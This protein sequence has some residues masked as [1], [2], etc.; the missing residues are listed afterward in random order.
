M[1]GWD[2]CIF[3][4]FRSSTLI[5]HR[6]CIGGRVAL[7][8]SYTGVVKSTTVAV[9]GA[10]GGVTRTI[11]QHLMITSTESAPD[12][13]RERSNDLEIPCDK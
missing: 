11:Q 9:Y 2:G 6:C 10:N 7:E 8:S 5:A 12:R 1:N 13:H 4:S 3:F